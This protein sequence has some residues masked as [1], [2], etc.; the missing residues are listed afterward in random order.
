MAPINKKQ[1]IFVAIGLMHILIVGGMPGL[2]WI[3]CRRSFV[4]LLSGHQLIPDFHPSASCQLFPLISALE[5]TALQPL[6]V[7]ANTA[8]E[9]LNEPNRVVSNP[10]FLKRHASTQTKAQSSTQPPMRS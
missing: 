10:V 6:S 2:S 9:P 3:S 4:S 7:S 5:T 8:Q 1:H